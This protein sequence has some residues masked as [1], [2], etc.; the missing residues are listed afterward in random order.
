MEYLG[1]NFNM[2]IYFN[3]MNIMPNNMGMM[4]NN[5]TPNNNYLPSN[6]ISSVAVVRPYQYPSCNI[7][8]DCLLLRFDLNNAFYILKIEKI[9][10]SNSILF[11]CLNEDDHITS[12]YE[13][14]CSLSYKE[15]H[16]MNKAFLICDD[17][18]QIFASI[19]NTL[20]KD[21]NISKP[22]IDFFQNNK[23]SLSFFFRIPLPSG[24]V[25][26]VNIILQKKKRNINIQFYKLAEKFEKMKKIVLEL[27][28]NDNND[29]NNKISNLK[30]IVDPSGVRE[31]FKDLMINPPEIY[32]MFEEK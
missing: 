19:E 26:D 1:N 10:S 11:S 31:P 15:L 23:D 18:K 30:N 9:E 14:T 24:K 25:E 21:I 17:I 7:T 16:N 32:K 4:N 12:L 27:G 6:L 2:N 3:N 5:M 20:T 13:Y 22:R 28:Y 29:N 8:N